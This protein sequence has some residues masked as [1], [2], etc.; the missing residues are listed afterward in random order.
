MFK[1]SLHLLKIEEEKLI[2]K[3]FDEILNYVSGITKR[4]MFTTK[5]YTKFKKD[6][7]KFPIPH[8]E[9]KLIDELIP[10]VDKINVT[11]ELLVTLKND[12][13]NKNKDNL[14]YEDDF[15]I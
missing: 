12:Y 6:P 3:P 14:N 8:L 9:F 1:I 5:L 2:K 10:E 11:D 13:D 7:T 15:I 4:E